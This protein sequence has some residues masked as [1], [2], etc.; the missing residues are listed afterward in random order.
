MVILYCIKV[1]L[2]RSFLLVYHFT[3]GTGVSS[4]A[5]RLWIYFFVSFAICPDNAS[6]AIR[7]GIQPAPQDCLL[8][9]IGFCYAV[10]GILYP[11]NLCP[12]IFECAAHA[13]QNAQ[14]SAD[15]FFLHTT[16]LPYTF[17]RI[18]LLRIFL[19]HTIPLLRKNST[20][21]QTYLLFMEHRSFN[22]CNVV[23]MK[24]LLHRTVLLSTVILY[25]FVVSS[26][27][28]S[29]K[30]FSNVSLFCLK[31]VVKYDLIC[32]ISNLFFTISLNTSALF[33]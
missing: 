26:I 21:T 15:F 24:W 5:S 1:V 17:V 4:F 16:V 20:F 10:Q 3:T 27:L 29:I 23:L 11:V 28:N 8:R 12:A 30:V 33:Q 25:F 6:T 31:S 18:S 32:G 19:L 7:F 13:D 2:S 14:K 22:M 9:T